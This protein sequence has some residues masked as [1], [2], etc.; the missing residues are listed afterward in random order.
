[1]ATQSTLA[2]KEV[3]QEILHPEGQPDVGYDV[4]ALLEEILKYKADQ[5]LPA[6]WTRAY[7]LTKGRHW[8]KDKGKVPLVTANLVLTH[9]QR[10]VSMLTD[11]NPTFNARQSGEVPPDQAQVVEL[12]KH[13]AAHWWEDTEQQGMLEA[14]VIAGET[15]GWAGEKVRFNPDKEYG[16]GEVETVPVDPFHFGWFPVDCMDPQDAEANLHFWP[17]PIREARR[18]WPK[19]A[20]QILPDDE[21]IAQ[22]GDSRDQILS[23]IARERDNWITSTIANVVRLFSN[24]AADMRGR[25]DRVLIIECWV[26]DYTRVRNDDG[27]EQDL[28]PGNI[29]CVWVCNAGKLVLED[30]ANPSINWDVLPVEQAAKTFLFDKFPFNTTISLRDIKSP[31][32]MTDIE[33]L[34]TIQLEI[35]KTLAQLTSIKDK[36]SKVVTINPANSGVA[37]SQFTNNPSGVINP[38]N[39]MVSAAIRHLESPQVNPEI[40]ELLGTYR[41]LF[42]LIS[43]SFDLEQAEAPGNN[44]IAYKAIAA[45]LERVA[46]LLRL[47]IRNYHRLIRNRGRMYLSCAMNWYVED[48]WVTFEEDDEEVVTRIS[49]RELIVPAKLSVVS[50]STMPVSKI[51]QREEALELARLGM[52]DNEELLKKLEWD[53][54]KNVIAR[55][56]QG[57]VGIAIER[58]I[59]MGALPPE[60]QQYLVELGP[61]D[62]K[63]FRRKYEKGELRP[64]MTAQQ[65]ALPAPESPVE[66]AEAQLK[67]A[68]AE[69]A[70]AETALIQEKIKTEQA[71]QQAIIA[72]IGFDQ[73]KLTITRAQ[74][75]SDIQSRAK[76]EM[77]ADVESAH[78]LSKTDRDEYREDE[79]RA[80]EDAKS[81]DEQKRA[82]RAEKREAEQAKAEQKRADHAEKREDKKVDAEIKTASMKQK[83]QGPYRE[84]G[85]KSNNKK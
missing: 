29:R 2:L 49:G 36:I 17:M 40:R 54:R 43:G 56:K 47:K 10:T 77:R 20:A 85:L 5:G 41:E 32:G 51:Q 63:E 65:Q 18:R 15:N 8:R 11:N 71:Q 38:K 31:W 37:N 55:M 64:I 84:S 80:I 76:Q 52:I 73:E 78:T 24:T 39:H 75:V 42:F 50:G 59:A 25:S 14:S 81:Q 30:R 69:K 33:Q 27:T 70:R 68:Q 1:M 44:A 67:A 74:T 28:Y 82:D 12:L 4:V 48:R 26:K 3:A 62:E 19:V 72:G 6:K 83:V 61:M 57:P 53:D 34:E 60:E 22:L 23:P 21:L 35:N 13:T 79:G 16:I 66:T 46:T 58:I 7:E 9:R 45:L